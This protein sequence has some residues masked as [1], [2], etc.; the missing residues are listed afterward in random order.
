MNNIEILSL[1]IND[2]EI[3][4]KKGINYIVGDNNSGKTT[5]FN[6]IKFSLG[7]LKQI[8]YKDINNTRLNLLIDERYYS[9]YRKLGNPNVIIHIEHEEMFFKP[10]SSELDSFLKKLLQPNYILD[11]DS[12]SIYSILELCFITEEKSLSKSKQLK[13]V[14]S[15]CGLNTKLLQLVKKDIDNLKNEVIL[16]Q[17]KE[18][19][20]NEFSE[21]LIESLSE[22]ASNIT[23]NINTTKNVFFHKYRA[24]EQLL[25]DSLM[26]FD[27]I[28]KKSDNHFEEIINY[29]ENTFFKIMEGFNIQ[30]TG[31]ESL[32]GYLKNSTLSMSYGQNTISRFALIMSIAQ[33]KNNLRINFPQILINDNFMSLNLNRNGFLHSDYFRDSIG[34]GSIDFQYIE[35]THDRNIPR[36]NVIYDLNSK[37]SFNAF[38]N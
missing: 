18:A 24:K 14:K 20:I 15:V 12:E 36:E 26:K 10:L 11:T 21:Q 17:E 34:C 32:H 8:S 22:E 6:A 7:L 31:M 9:F 13:S 29:L 5:I 3:V 19:L 30:Y 1:S 27:S 35:F 4:F 16:N 23:R 2:T 33:N 25:N 37:R 28:Q 38:R